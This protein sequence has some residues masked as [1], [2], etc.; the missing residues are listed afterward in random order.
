MSGNKPKTYKPF[1]LSTTE[2]RPSVGLQDKVDNSVVHAV[3]QL[4]NHVFTLRGLLNSLEIPMPDVGDGV[5]LDQA[6]EIAKVYQTKA[7]CADTAFTNPKQLATG[8]GAVYATVARNEYVYLQGG[9]VASPVGHFRVYRIGQDN[10][11]VLVGSLDTTEV[12]ERLVVSGLYAFGARVDGGSA[13][14][15]IIT[16]AKPNAPVE[17][18]LFNVGSAI[19]G[20]AVQGRFVACACADGTVKLVDFAVPAS[21]QVIGSAS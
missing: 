3:K 9:I 17:V 14:L 7:A 2:Y 19:N 18:L 20:L 16:V 6:N 15:T 21:P 10:A 4:E 5:T 1:D 13:N 12:F 11:P 8:L